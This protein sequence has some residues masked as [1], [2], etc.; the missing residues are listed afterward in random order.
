MQK[1]RLAYT[2][3]KLEQE[4]QY[5]LIARPTF[6]FAV[7]S[8][9]AIQQYSVLGIHV[10][11]QSNGSIPTLVLIHVNNE[12]L[13]MNVE[14]HDSTL[15]LVDQRINVNRMTCLRWP[16]HYL[17]DVPSIAT[18]AVRLTSTDEFQRH[19]KIHLDIYETVLHT[20]TLLQSREQR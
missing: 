19:E 13:H 1:S 7:C 18:P 17:S 15:P 16:W 14:F 3:V 9:H 6:I 5:H 4:W 8:F 20:D 10:S 11:S 2:G 12:A